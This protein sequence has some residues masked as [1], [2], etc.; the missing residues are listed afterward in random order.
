MRILHLVHQF[1]PHFVGG[2]E[3]NTAGLAE[4]QV[5]QGHDVAVFVPAPIERKDGDTLHVADEGCGRVYRVAVGQRS[6]TAVFRDTLAPDGPIAQGLA[7]VLADFRP[8]LIHIQHLMGMPVRAIGKILQVYEAPVVV[9]LLDFWWV[10]ANAQL[11]TNDTEQICAGPDLFLNCG[12]CAAARANLPAAMG[13]AVAP[14]FGLRNRWLRPILAHAD[15]VFAPT[16]FTADWYSTRIGF[17]HPVQV[18]PLGFEPPKANEPQVKPKAAA[19]PLKLAYVGGLSQQKGVHVIIEAINQ[20]EDVDLTLTV[21]G[22]ESKFPGYVAQLKGAADERVTFRGK[23]SP[24]AVRELMAESDLLLV[25][26]VW[27]ETYAIV[28]SEAF[29]A[30]IPVMVS[31]L[32]ALAER[33]DEGVN[34]FKVQAGDVAAWAEAIGRVANNRQRVAEMGRK[35]PEPFTM[36]DHYA[37]V[38]LLYKEAQQRY[39]RS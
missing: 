24:A 12:R 33:M 31:D 16:R 3:L 20:L 6:A 4:Q 21:G 10:C 29:A 5:K 1:A 13:V 37:T 32:G 14:I 30:G 11:L 36:A 8:E 15:G 39:Q 22:D 28:V 17:D 2:T 18:I 34:G 9:T 7:Q 27:Y 23:I 35:R 25:P 26:S 19:G 38:M